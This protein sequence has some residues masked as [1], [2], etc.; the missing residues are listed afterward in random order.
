MVLTIHAEVQ[1]RLGDGHS[2]QNQVEV[3]AEE[4]SPEAGRVRQRREPGEEPLRTS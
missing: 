4:H 1:I 2:P 3:R